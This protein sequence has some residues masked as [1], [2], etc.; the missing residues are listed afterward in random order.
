[1]LFHCWDYFCPKLFSIDRCSLKRMQ[2]ADIEY[3]TI[4]IGHNP[5]DALG[6]L[7]CMGRCFVRCVIVANIKGILNSGVD[8]YEYMITLSKD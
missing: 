2:E 8:S 5:T 7:K 4:V 3:D 6:T 1:M